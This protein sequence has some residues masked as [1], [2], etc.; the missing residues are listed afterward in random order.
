MELKRTVKCTGRV[1]ATY[2]E[3]GALSLKVFATASYRDDDVN[4]TT[5]A[6]VSEVSIARTTAVKEALKAALDEALPKLGEKI[7]DA[8]AVSRTAA[9]NAQEMT[10]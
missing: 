6:E 8:I 4:A 7:G 10:G 3:D 2:E 5:T 1:S 9:R